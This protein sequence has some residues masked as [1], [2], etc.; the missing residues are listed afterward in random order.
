MHLTDMV[1]VVVVVGL[2]LWGIFTTADKD[3]V[4]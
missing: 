4:G 2:I 1:V 3:D